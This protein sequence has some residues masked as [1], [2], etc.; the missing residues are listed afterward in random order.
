[1][2]DNDLVTTGLSFG[3]TRKPDA[4]PSHPAIPHLLAAITALQANKP[5]SA[6]SAMESAMDAVS[7]ADGLMAEF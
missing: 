1:M 2:A 5:R 6:V 3:G 7:E 4:V